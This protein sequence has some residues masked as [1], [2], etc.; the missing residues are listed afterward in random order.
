MFTV[1]F[2]CKTI[3]TKCSGI[4]KSDSFGDRHEA[5][6]LYGDVYQGLLSN[7]WTIGQ[8]FLVVVFVKL[9]WCKF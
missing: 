9:S 4:S 2:I 3:C 8:S 6:V 5:V 7:L 1:C